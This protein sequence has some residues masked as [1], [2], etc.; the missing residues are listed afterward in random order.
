MNFAF[1]GGNFPLMVLSEY[2]E[3]SLMQERVLAPPWHAVFIPRVCWGRLSG[4]GRG[5]VL[6]P[7]DAS[8]PGGTTATPALS[9]ISSSYPHRPGTT[10]FL[11]HF[12]QDM[13]R[14][15]P[16][17]KWLTYSWVILWRDFTLLFISLQQPINRYIQEVMAYHFH[18]TT[19]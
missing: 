12:P 1:L 19:V 13:H 5:A 7:P 6:P 9:F 14:H 16:C 10:R 17:P 8:R 11:F 3:Q 15:G 4:R 2:T 18:A